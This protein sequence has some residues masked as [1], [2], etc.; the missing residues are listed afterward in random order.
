VFMVLPLVSLQSLI[1]AFQR[2]AVSRQQKLLRFFDPFSFTMEMGIQTFTG[3]V[4]GNTS[5]PLLIIG[6]TAGVFSSPALSLS[7]F[8][9]DL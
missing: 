8:P 2:M 5:F 3:P 7:L 6:N 9:Y 4:G 1:F